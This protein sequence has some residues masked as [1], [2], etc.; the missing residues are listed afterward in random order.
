[1]REF[2]S[3]G[4]LLVLKVV[5]ALVRTDYGKIVEDLNTSEPPV[6]P[7]FSNSTDSYTLMKELIYY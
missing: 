2:G 5:Y 4:V 1:M 7:K 3:S 6:F